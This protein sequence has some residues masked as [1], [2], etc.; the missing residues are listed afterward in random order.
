MNHTNRVE[1]GLSKYTA[2]KRTTVVAEHP[3]PGRTSVINP[4]SPQ[5]ADG[6]GQPATGVCVNV[7]D[8]HRFAI[9]SSNTML[10][11][12]PKIH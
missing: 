12:S 8:S 11:S 3:S 4:T 9:D 7:M 2:T 6:H 1:G 10:I 5:S